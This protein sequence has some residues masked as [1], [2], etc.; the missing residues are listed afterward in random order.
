MAPL[1]L[2]IISLLVNKF[3][4]VT[5]Q[6]HNFVVDNRRAFDQE[7]YESVLDEAQCDQQ[8]R[9]LWNNS[10]GLEFI[11]A[12]GKLPSGISGL[13][14][15][16]LGDYY[17]CLGI[18]E[19]IQELDIRGKYC[20]I[21]IPLDQDIIIRPELP[22]I[23]GLPE[24]PELPWPRP[25]NQTVE[26]LK[27]YMGI[28]R[29]AHMIV[30]AGEPVDAR[31]FPVFSIASGFTLGVCVPRVCTPTQAVNFFQ[32]R[33]RFLNFTF[34]EYYCRLPNDKPFSPA[35]YVAM[36]VFSLLAL[37]IIISTSYD[38]CQLLVLKRDSSEVNTLYRSFSVYTNTRRFLTFNSG[39]GTLE[40]VDGIR[41]ISM[42]W[43]IV[44]HTYGMTLL[45]FLHNLR[46][47][48]AWISA[49]SSAWVNSAPITVDTFFMLSGILCV[50]ST[51]GKIGRNRFFRSLHLF[52]LNRLL[53]MFPLLA[54][55]ILLQASVFL[56]LSDGPFWQNV[57]QA[58][59]SCRYYWWS[60][61]LH[62]Q[63]YVNPLELCLYQ[64]WYLSVDI[65]MYIICP[66]VLF[67]LFGRSLFAWCALA[68][69]TVLSL[70]ATTTY[71]FI[72]N[73]SASLNNP[74]RLLEFNDYLKTYYVNTLTR[75]APF[76]IGMI[77]G[78][79][80][81]RYRGSKIR[82]PKIYVAI[83]WAMAFIM[84]AFCVISIYP[85]S[86]TDHT[87]QTFDN[88]LNAYMRAIWASAVGWL[89]FACVHGYGGPINWFL[90]LQVW[91]LPSR[92]S[93]AVYLIHLPIIILANGTWVK[94]HYFSNGDAMFRYMS[95]IGYSFIAAFILCIA[96]DAPFS[97]LQKL[98]FGGGKK[99]ARKPQ[100]ESRTSIVGD[101]KLIRTA[102]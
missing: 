17:Q 101:N 62:V 94:T 86:Q 37:I 42:L 49:F 47:T 68:T 76:C 22:E 97:T 32:D 13:H 38:M 91:K 60:A 19:L 57:A 82:I 98:L 41:A 8:M 12:S 93:Y 31:I 6:A 92:L 15:A 64:T 24:L 50:Y 66:I 71:S 14:L 55:V 78:Y 27:Q 25:P 90:S 79:L 52:Y 63:N 100:T 67:W 4:S 88:F 75:A 74:S 56:H 48:L 102:L 18:N 53:R 65:Q 2:F 26:E 21:R 81:N 96:I 95:E 89:I 44:G 61:L 77:Y 51:I 58:T 10:L 11:D 9:F 3:T 59:M 28:R 84:M 16:D 29:W 23:P 7:L 45:A 30:G 5:S 1:Y 43:V 83:L 35:D 34:T 73:F 33:V 36:V 99:Q 70:V 80:L 46:D 54:A 69:I 85:V 20:T 40:C 39:P 72:F 87:G